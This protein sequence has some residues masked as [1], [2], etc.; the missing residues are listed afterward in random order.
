MTKREIALTIQARNNLLRQRV[1]LSNNDAHSA[2]LSAGG[3]SQSYTSRSLAEVDAEIERLD[4]IIAD[5]KN[6]LLGR[7]VLNIDYP[8]WC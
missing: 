7:G 8:R 1:A 5:Y 4:K 3:G 2:S 6:S